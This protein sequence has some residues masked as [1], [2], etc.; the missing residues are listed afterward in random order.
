MMP[1]KDHGLCATIAAQPVLWATIFTGITTCLV[2]WA[3]VSLCDTICWHGDTFGTHDSGP[4]AECNFGLEHHKNNPQ[5]ALGVEWYATQNTCILQDCGKASHSCQF[6][7][8]QPGFM[9]EPSNAASALAFLWVSFYILFLGM[10]DKRDKN[11]SSRAMPGGVSYIFAVTNLVHFLGCFLNHSSRMWI[12]HVGDV[13]GMQLIV[14][15]L[16][17]YSVIR[18]FK[19]AP[20]TK[21]TALLLIVVSPTIVLASLSQYTDKCCEEKE[22]VLMATLFAA[23][24][25]VNWSEIHRM[26]HSILALLLG[27]GFQIGDK[28][29]REWINPAW[30]VHGHA[31]W[32]VATA[33]AMLFMYLT[34]RDPPSD[35]EEAGHEMDGP[36]SV[37]VTQ[38]NI[39]TPVSG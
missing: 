39:L 9:R 38:D 29:E 13:F 5:F 28:A 2:V 37:R 11:R 36:E 10:K 21:I 6:G 22:L 7:K 20:P 27:V 32:H 18:R 33:V 19:I 31:I 15:T 4:W 3:Q 1:S 24:L 17:I 30:Y 12:F 25:F 8:G 23:I 35:Q 34:L 26:K 16:F 14:W